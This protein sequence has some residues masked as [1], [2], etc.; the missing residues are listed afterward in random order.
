MNRTSHPS[1]RIALSLAAAV[2]SAVAGLVL[3]PWDPRATVPVAPGSDTLTT[4]YTWWGVALFAVV[5]AVAAWVTGRFGG[6]AGA[7]MAAAGGVPSALLLVSFLAHEPESDGFAGLWSLNWLFA[8]CLMVVGAGVVAMVAQDGRPGLDRMPD[9]SLKLLVP[10]AVA[11]AVSFTAFLV[12]L[13]SSGSGPV[14]RGCAALAALALGY[15]AGWI[16][17]AVGRRPAT[18]TLLTVGAVLLMAAV[19]TVSALLWEW[20]A[21]EALAWGI[22]LLRCGA[23]TAA[24][25]LPR[26]PNGP[27]SG[28]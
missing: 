17:R 10:A 11:G 15:G 1:F 16:L 12:Q 5:L 26:T 23:G 14:V 6:G 28:A 4:G 24:A 8:A 19:E 20:R 25:Y 9:A 27:P 13:V 18:A 7:A 3:L 22:T 21:P 2:C